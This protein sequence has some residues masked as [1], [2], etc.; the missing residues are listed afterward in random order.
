MGE[1]GG[2]GEREEGQ[3]RRG[4]REGK[5]PTFHYET[6]SSTNM[7]AGVTRPGKE[8]KIAGPTL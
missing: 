5:K 4:K 6:R 8:A 7:A 1:E 3:R 2:E